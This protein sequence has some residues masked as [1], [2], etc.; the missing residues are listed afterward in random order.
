MPDVTTDR[1]RLLDVLALGGEQSTRALTV[2]LGAHKPHVLVDLQH[3][4]QAGLVARRWDGG[5]TLWR[6][7]GAEREAA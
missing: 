1:A 4:E 2:R 7:V 5:C 6:R 3:L